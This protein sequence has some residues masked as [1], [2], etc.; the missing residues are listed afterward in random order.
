VGTSSPRPTASPLRGCTR[1]ALRHGY[2][3][4]RNSARRPYYRTVYWRS[5]APTTVAPYLGTRKIAAIPLHW[6][7]SRRISPFWQDLWRDS[8]FPRS[9]AT[10]SPQTEPEKGPRANSVI[11]LGLELAAAELGPLRD[12]AVRSLHLREGGF[13]ADRGGLGKRLNKQVQ[14][15][16]RVA[17]NWPSKKGNGL[18]GDQAQKGR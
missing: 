3:T 9:S 14:E 17:S 18:N 6:A 12:T 5:Q 10:R 8:V 16:K 13:F 2:Q 4:S 11:E 7:F 1:W 15:N